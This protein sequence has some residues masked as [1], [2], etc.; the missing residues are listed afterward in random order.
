MVSVPPLFPSPLVGE[1]VGEGEAN[2]EVIID[3]QI[4]NL[5]F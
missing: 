1:G 3:R 5:S 4:K 2:F